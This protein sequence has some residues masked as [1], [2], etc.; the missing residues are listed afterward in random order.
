[1]KPEGPRLEDEGPTAGMGLLGRGSQAHPHQLESLGSVV[2]SLSG[3]RG[4]VS[5][6]KVFPHFKHSG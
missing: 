6:A 5:A 4:G 2:S 1:M 3:I